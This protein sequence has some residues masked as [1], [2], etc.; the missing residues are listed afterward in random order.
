MTRG[1]SKR[2]QKTDVDTLFG[3]ILVAF[4]DICPTLVFA[5]YLFRFWQVVGALLGAFVGFGSPF[6]DH[7]ALNFR[8]WID[9]LPNMI[10]ALIFDRFWNE[11]L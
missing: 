6:R 11:I 4:S 1:G 9:V 3:V 7:F 5:S 2:E 8:S 10:F